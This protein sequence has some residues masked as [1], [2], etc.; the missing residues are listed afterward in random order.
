[1]LWYFRRLDANHENRE[2]MAIYSR[3]NRILSHH[4]WKNIYF[5]RITCMY[6]DNHSNMKNYEKQTHSLFMIDLET[7]T[8]NIF[9]DSPWI[10]IVCESTSLRSKNCY[11]HMISSQEWIWSVLSHH[12]LN[13][14][15]HLRIINPSLPFVS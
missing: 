7:N 6:V 4:L 1:M 13:L 10:D 5:S 11:T 8:S 14:S 9:N 12:K 2:N 3:L 15:L